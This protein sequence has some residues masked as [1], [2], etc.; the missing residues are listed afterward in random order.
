MRSHVLVD[1]AF[2]A[3]FT[4]RETAGPS[5]ALVT[6]LLLLAPRA[7]AS[8]VAHPAAPSAQLHSL[9]ARCPTPAPGIRSFEDE[10]VTRAMLH[11]RG[12]ALIIGANTGDVGTDPSFAILRSCGRH[13]AKVLVE[14]IPP[15]F[16]VLQRN[17]AKLINATAVHAAISPDGSEDGQ[18]LTIFC[19]GQ[20]GNA[21]HQK[22]VDLAEHTYVRTRGLK[23]FFSQLCTLNR[24]M[25][26]EA[27][28]GRPPRANDKFITE[29]QVPLL[30][31][32]QLI[33]RHVAAPVRYV[34]IDVQGD[35]D[36]VLAQIPLGP[37][38]LPT[39]IIFE[40]AL[41][42]AQR[43]AAAVTRLRQ[44]GYVSC[45]RHQNI[46]SHQ[47]WPTQRTEADDARCILPTSNV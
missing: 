31:V 13:Y 47:S 1:T 10:A 2:S 6:A 22:Y 23:P 17:A 20:N 11:T 4:R 46:V 36:K 35:D 15:I 32:R 34:Q 41:I 16:R 5:A 37:A 27:I 45:T 24:S 28:P 42:G 25:I 14:P 8:S 7:S 9:P 39:L 29:Q 43:S 3:V 19:M 40:H 30:S 21:S 44:F 26:Y 12:T 38:L 33:A 18:S